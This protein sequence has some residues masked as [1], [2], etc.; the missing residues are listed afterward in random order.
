MM[1]VDLASGGGGQQP[2]DVDMIPLARLPGSAA[3]KCQWAG[4]VCEGWVI[5]FLLDE[6]TRRL[7]NYWTLSNGA[8]SMFNEYNN[9][10]R[11]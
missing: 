2:P 7:K 4:A 1:D 3:G 5:H 6:P 11:A 8:I 10:E 9:G